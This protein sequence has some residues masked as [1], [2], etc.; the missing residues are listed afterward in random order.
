MSGFLLIGASIWLTIVILVLAA[1]RVAARADVTAERH[2]REA[3]LD[4]PQAAPPIEPTALPGE[5]RRRYLA[6][7]EAAT[8][9]LVAVLAATTSTAADW[10]PLALPGLLAVRA[11][12]GDLQPFRARRFRVSASFPAL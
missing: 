1:L 8:V 9:A 12:A 7:A 4:L 3:G 11:I 10:Q 6:V 2:A 5:S